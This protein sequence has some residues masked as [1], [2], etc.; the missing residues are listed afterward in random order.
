[1]VKVEIKIFEPTMCCPGG[2]C[3]PAPDE[4]LLKFSEVLKMIGKKYGQDV[5]I[6]R[7]SINQNSSL[8]FSDQDILMIIN[9]EGMQTLPITKINGNIAFKGV[10]PTFDMLDGKIK[11][12]VQEKNY[13]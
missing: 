9:E 11:S 8:F 4:I 13:G 1:M 12:I 6:E 5:S 3:G 10:Y 2:G 7:G